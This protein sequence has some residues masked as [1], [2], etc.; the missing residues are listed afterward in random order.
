MEQGRLPGQVPA[1]QNVPG[2]LGKRS[3]HEING[4]HHHIQ[5]QSQQQQHLQQQ[6]PLQQPQ[7]LASSVQVAPVVQT[8][9]T[10]GGVVSIPS[11]STMTPASWP[12]NLA[13]NTT[14][15]AVT[16]TETAIPGRTGAVEALRNTG[17]DKQ[18]MKLTSVTPGAGAGVP[19]AATGLDV[20]SNGGVITPSKNTGDTPVSTAAT[21]SGP[22]VAQRAKPEGPEGKPKKRARTLTKAEVKRRERELKLKE[23]LLTIKEYAPTIPV[24]A[25]RFHLQRGGLGTSTNSQM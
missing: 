20:V 8:V 17:G 22:G 4:A 11:T 13:I 1:A 18:G 14:P 3:I 9:V 24:E 19:A 7:Q 2:T 16:V 21:S 5:H 6:Q 12:Q 25:T 15:T 23:F 10:P